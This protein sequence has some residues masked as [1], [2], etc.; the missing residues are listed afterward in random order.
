MFQRDS[1]E[2]LRETLQ[3]LRVVDALREL[4]KSPCAACAAEVC[5]H[6]AQMSMALGFKD[7]P[8]CLRC[9]SRELDRSVREVR[10]RLRTYFASRRC[11]RVAWMWCNQEEGFDSAEADPPCIQA[12]GA[13][14]PHVDSDG[15]IPR[16]GLEPP[17][18]A[19]E[20]D[21]GDM[22][23]GDLVLQLRRRLRDLQPGQV[24]KL[25]ATDAGAAE[26]LPAWSRLT[27]HRLVAVDP[28]LY[29]IQRKET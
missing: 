18:P 1:V 13:E 8:R 2:E 16:P 3:S 15:P 27:G 24:L 20:W 19:S 29:W 6:Q 9:L 28:P 17:A 23:C 5:G 26:D 12:G 25:R 4:R 10:E 22:S 7:R 14:A 21:A 11:Q